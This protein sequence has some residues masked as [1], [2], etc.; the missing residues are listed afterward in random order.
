M[1][2]LLIKALKKRNLL[3]KINFV[4]TV[5]VQNEKVQEFE[6]ILKKVIR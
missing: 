4:K 3:T 2:N 6:L 5:F 1:S